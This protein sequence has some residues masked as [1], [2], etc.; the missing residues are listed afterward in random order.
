MNYCTKTRRY[1]PNISLAAAKPAKAHGQQEPRLL[2]ACIFAGEKHLQNQ[3]SEVASVRGSTLPKQGPTTLWEPLWGKAWVFSPFLWPSREVRPYGGDR[4]TQKV[5]LQ[6]ED[7]SC[8][9]F[10]TW[11]WDPDGSTRC[12]PWGCSRQG[13]RERAVTEEQRCLQGQGESTNPP[14]FCPSPG[15]HMHT[16]HSRR[17]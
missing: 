4:V 16:C 6:C 13:I 5:V 9:C 8:H 11:F 2:T 14:S 12:W 17:D 1:C 7:C 10:P 15:T 3:L